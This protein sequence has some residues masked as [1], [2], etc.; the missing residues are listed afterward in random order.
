MPCAGREFTAAQKTCCALGCCWCEQA[1]CVRVAAGS[2]CSLAKCRASSQAPNAERH[3]SLISASSQ[4]PNAEP[5][6]KHPMPSLITST[7][8]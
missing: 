2:V 7:Q 4:A 1:Q 6:H 8:C 3:L 5:H